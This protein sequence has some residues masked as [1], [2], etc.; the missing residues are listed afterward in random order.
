M[1]ELKSLLK[2]NQ[3]SDNRWESAFD[4]YSM[5]IEYYSDKYYTY[6]E[7]SNQTRALGAYYS[8]KKAQE[9]CTQCAVNISFN[10]INNLKKKLEPYVDV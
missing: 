6:R 7:T 4:D 2:F 10:R 3:I 5:V 9:A 8:F 1:S